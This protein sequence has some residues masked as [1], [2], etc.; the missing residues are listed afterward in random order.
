MRTRGTVSTLRWIS[1]FLVLGIVILTTLQLV[2]YSRLRVIFPPG[3]VIAGVPVGSLNRQEAAQRLLA[4]YTQ[5]VEIRNN[6]QIIHFN[7]TLVGFQL[8][9]ESMMDAADLER[10]QQSFWLGFWDFLWG[11]TSK[12][13]VVPLRSNYSEARLRAYL[14]DEISAR[15]DQQPVPASPS[16]GT[17]NF[18]PGIP[19]T[20]ID[21]NRAVLLIE[22]AMRSPNS[23]SLDLPLSHIQPP[24]P[25]FQNVEILLKQTIYDVAK[26]DGLVG[27]YLMDLQTAQEI[28]FLFQKGNNYP[29]QTDLAFTAASIIKIP[30]MVS[31]FKRLGADPD[32]ET[33][34]LLEDMIIKSGNDPADWLMERVIDKLRAPLEVT[35][36]LE[37]LG[38][39][40]TFLAGQFYPG[41]PLLKLF[42][43]PANSRSDVF[44][45][46][47]IYNQTTPTEIGSLLADIYQCYHSKGGALF[48]VFPGEI[49]QAECE[50]MINYLT[51][52][53]LG[54]LIEAGV[55]DGTQV[56]HK[57]GWVT[58]LGIINTIGDAGIVFTPGGNYVLVIFLYHPVQLIWEP[59][60]QLIADLSQAVYN[61]YNL[62]SQ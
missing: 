8:D 42:H 28:H 62:P 46:P 41:A 50:I 21:I 30:I 4:V 54:L 22:N 2:R 19:G 39:N 25:S 26:F 43:T 17:V 18:K 32:P 35:A 10:S 58:Y 23:R 40:N 34:K 13:A 1:V 53:K 9:L 52:N 27:L 29:N 12:P 5:P 11:F 60:S 44:T 16:I 6:T 7:P 47:D 33:V 31:A 24:R 37:S 57:H 56:A 49:T 38:L 55:P 20:S 14:Q 59:A 61:F 48:A 15:Y 36:D 45:D 3:M 51:R